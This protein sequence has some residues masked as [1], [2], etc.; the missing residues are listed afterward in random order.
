M[1]DVALSLSHS[2]SV[3]SGRFHDRAGPLPEALSPF[4]AALR[5]FA[6]GSALPTP[7]V[8]TLSFSEAS[9]WAQPERRVAA[10]DSDVSRVTRV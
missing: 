6:R 4:R 3:S 7:L 9:E 8:A 1:F 5:V 10:L 2:L